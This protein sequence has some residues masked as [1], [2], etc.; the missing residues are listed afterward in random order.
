MHFLTTLL[1]LAPAALAAPAVSQPQPGAS[2]PEGF[3]LTEVHSDGT[4]VRTP[5]DDAANLTSVSVSRRTTSENPAATSKLGKRFTDCWDWYLDAAGTD[6]GVDTWKDYLRTQTLELRS[7]VDSNW[8]AEYINDGVSVYY[9]INARDTFGSLNLEDFNY[10]LVQMD[11]NCRP[12]QASYFRWDGS[13]EI[14]GKASVN[15]RV[16]RG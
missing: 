8:Y 16:C 9:C 12:Y 11:A 7:P 13:A 15:D 10:A 3:Y 14:V 1:A 6:R 2:V 5:L 4:L